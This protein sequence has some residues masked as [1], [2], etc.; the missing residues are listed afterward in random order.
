[1]R[2]LIASLVQ[3]PESFPESKKVEGTSGAIFE[4]EYG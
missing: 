1:M 3:Y 2:A 4:V